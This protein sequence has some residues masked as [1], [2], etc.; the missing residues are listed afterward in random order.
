LNPYFLIGYIFLLI[1][2]FFFA[3]KDTRE[4]IIPDKWTNPLIILSVIMYFFAFNFFSFTFYLYFTI[5]VLLYLFFVYLQ[6]AMH[7]SGLSLGTGDVK[8][9]LLIFALIPFSSSAFVGIPFFNILFSTIVLVFLMVSFR[10]IYYLLFSKIK[11]F[12]IMYGS[13]IDKTEIRLAP[14]IYFSLIINFFI[15]IL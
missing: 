11:I 10:L 14:I 13:S 4:G 2:G 15:L 7:Y 5:L 9:L 12:K 1:I 3:R 8:F 6:R